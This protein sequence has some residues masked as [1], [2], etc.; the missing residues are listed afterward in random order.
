MLVRGQ[1]GREA[2]GEIKEIQR[3]ELPLRSH[4]DER[5]S[6]ENMGNN[7]VILG[8]TGHYRS[9]ESCGTPETHITLYVNYASIKR[10]NNTQTVRDPETQLTKSQRTRE[11]QAKPGL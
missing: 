11:N 6:T 10:K 3:H 8:S 9:V 4:E 7:T 1:V 5:Y 2:L